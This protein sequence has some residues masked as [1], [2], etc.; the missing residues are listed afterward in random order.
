[1]IDLKKKK[2][3][4]YINQICLR[5]GVEKVCYNLINNLTNPDK[6]EI[7]ILTTVAYL[8]DDLNIGI[9]NKNK[10]VKR[11]FLMY[12]EFSDNAF[13]RFFQRVYNKIA[14][15][16]IEMLL[17]MK[18]WDTAISAQEA[19]YA[20]LI[21]KMH[22]DKKLLWIHNDF[23]VT[24]W[25]KKYFDNSHKK[26]AEC[27]KKFDKI[28]C[29]SES[30]KESIKD[31]LGLEENVI[32]RYNPIDTD[33][34]DKKMSEPIAEKKNKGFLFVAVGRL[35]YQKGY[36]RML[37]I[38]KKL[39]ADGLNFELWMLGDGE[40]REWVQNYIL[41][42]HLDNVRLLGNVENPFAYM[43]IADCILSTSRFE[44]FNT[45]LQEA[46]YMGKFIVT[47]E[48]A[49]ARELLGENEYGIVMENDDAKM[50]EAIK[51]VLENPS[52]KE[53][54]EEKIKAR[55]DFVDIRKRV[56]KIEELF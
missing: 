45:A 31:T 14:P 46:A 12:D 13:Y 22:A 10:N 17:K 35:C 19:Y 32:V 18:K 55:K 30:V 49:G 3:L 6:Y 20:K 39:N 23:N 9:Y 33:E 11:F 47:A 4:I 41:Q 42:N 38:V 51:K 29:V 50:Y 34:I 21:V 27:Y 52:C 44:G 24:D 56:E 28:V 53:E 16:V 26:E 36:D 43:K 25:S 48:C 37:E 15:T 5:G 40:D 8:S 1:M 7:T 2:I 54:Y